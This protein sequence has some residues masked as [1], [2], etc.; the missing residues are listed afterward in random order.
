MLRNRE[1]GD[2]TTLPEVMR[3][4]GG[5]EVGRLGCSGFTMDGRKRR[6]I[7]G[8][9][10]AIRVRLERERERERGR[11]GEREAANGQN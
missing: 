4:L 10:L 8:T 1:G 9:L 2:D 11:D 3:I 6:V 5:V 7:L